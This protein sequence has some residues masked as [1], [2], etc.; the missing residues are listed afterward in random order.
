MALRII[1]LLGGD[2]R[3]V[4]DSAKNSEPGNQKHSEER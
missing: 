1:G 3:A 4:D 2:E